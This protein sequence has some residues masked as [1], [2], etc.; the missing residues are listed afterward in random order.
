MHYTE[1][2][3]DQ[4]LDRIR[5]YLPQMI[6][7]PLGWGRQLRLINLFPPRCV[8]AMDDFIV[9]E[10]NELEAC[11]RHHLWTASTLLAFRIFED[12]VKVHV[13]YDL[14][15]ST[16]NLDLKACINT[17]RKTCNQ[18]YVNQM[19]EL[20]KIRNRAMHPKDQFD[21]RS[22]VDVVLQVCDITMFVYAIPASEQNL[23][24]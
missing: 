21:A 19:H 18:Q 11:L 23:A 8:E 2:K 14:K 9:T 20:R 3:L 17:M 13:K 1:D 15:K 4:Y 10:I 5:H 6:N 7:M 12:T 16:R 22:A 24:S